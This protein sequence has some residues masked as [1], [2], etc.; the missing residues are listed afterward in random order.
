[1]SIRYVLDENKE[2]VKHEFKGGH[3]GH[4][5]KRHGLMRPCMQKRDRPPK[6]KKKVA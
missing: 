4:G 5:K 3:K 2:W 1:M 6:G